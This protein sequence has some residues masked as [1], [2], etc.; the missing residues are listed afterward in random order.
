MQP[1]TCQVCRIYGLGFRVQGLG[2]QTVE[3][4]TV[5]KYQVQNHSLGFSYSMSGL[6]L[7]V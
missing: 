7:G 1:A 6:D 4:A 5:P 3:K 2:S